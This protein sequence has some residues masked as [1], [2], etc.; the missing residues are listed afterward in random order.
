M[1]LNHLLYALCDLERGK[2]LPLLKAVKVKHRAPDLLAQEAFR[3]FAAAV[4][5]MLIEDGM[6]RREAAQKVA[7][8]LNNLGYRNGSKKI[9]A[10]Q[11][12]AWRYRILRER[13]A[14]SHAADRF[15]RVKEATRAHKVDPISVLH[16]LTA[17]AP[18]E[19][20]RN[21]RA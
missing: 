1:P 19:I 8:I 10:N 7:R 21:P 12:A 18:P 3:A 20:P 2:T 5:D 16:R 15:H 14:E 11:V 13:R 6:A 17:L 4:L 9:S